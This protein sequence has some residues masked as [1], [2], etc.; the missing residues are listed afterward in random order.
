MQSGWFQGSPVVCTA[1]AQTANESLRPGDL[2]LVWIFRRAQI[3]LTPSP[4]RIPLAVRNMTRC[5]ESPTAS[6]GLLKP[7]T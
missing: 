3:D 1:H 2:R 7:L 6:M 5:C 4:A